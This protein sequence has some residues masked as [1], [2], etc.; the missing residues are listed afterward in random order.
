M[1]LAL[2]CAILV[3]HFVGAAPCLAA[4]GTCGCDSQLLISTQD[5][6]I[7]VTCQKLCLLAS[8]NTEFLSCERWEK[9]VNRC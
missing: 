7:A 4:G 9:A 6:P 3:K 1:T 5:A 2:L 8:F